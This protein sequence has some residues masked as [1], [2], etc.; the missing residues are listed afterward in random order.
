MSGFHEKAHTSRLQR[1][2]VVGNANL[3]WVLNAN[4]ADDGWYPET[5]A[6]V[7]VRWQRVGDLIGS[8]F[9]PHTS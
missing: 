2:R 4:L 5:A 6:G 3:N 8:G 9:E 1:W 7:L